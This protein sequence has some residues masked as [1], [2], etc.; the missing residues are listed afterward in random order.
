[1]HLSRLVG[2]A[3]EITMNF[4]YAGCSVI[5]LQNIFEKY[6]EHLQTSKNEEKYSLI[7]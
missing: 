2:N 4:I 1:M 7:V 3:Q 5:A 6:R